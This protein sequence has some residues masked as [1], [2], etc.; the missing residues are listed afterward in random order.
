MPNPRLTKV[1][2]KNKKKRIAKRKAARKAAPKNK[3]DIFAESMGSVA[4]LVKKLRVK[5]KKKS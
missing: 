3:A 5:K 4:N 1:K 2:A